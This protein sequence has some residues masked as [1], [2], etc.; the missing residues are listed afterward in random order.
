MFIKGIHRGGLGCLGSK[1][2]YENLLLPNS[3]CHDFIRYYRYFHVA[4]ILYYSKEITK[5]FEYEH[6]HVKVYTDPHKICL[7]K[8]NIFLLTIVKLDISTIWAS[9]DL[10][11]SRELQFV[12]S[13]FPTFFTFLFHTRNIFLENVKRLSSSKKRTTIKNNRGLNAIS[14]SK[15]NL[16]TRLRLLGVGKRIYVQIRLG[17]GQC[18]NER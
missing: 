1:T 2:R 11:G 16:F 15:D 13:I 6:D 8:D 14:A 5:L 18:A 3:D 4:I 9:G 17:T 10:R 7:Q 12:L